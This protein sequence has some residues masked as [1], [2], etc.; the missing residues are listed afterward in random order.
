[1]VFDAATYG[2]EN[3]VALSNAVAGKWL[4]IEIYIGTGHIDGSNGTGYMFSLRPYLYGES[5]YLADLS[6]SKYPMDSIETNVSGTVLRSYQDRAGISVFK[7]SDGYRVDDRN[8]SGQNRTS[9]FLHVVSSDYAALKNTYKTMS[10]KIKMPTI[11]QNLVFYSGANSATFA[12][13]FSQ[14]NNVNSASNYF[15][16]L[17]ENGD[18][19]GYNSD[20]KLQ[21]NVWYTVVVHLEPC[22]T[23]KFVFCL[24]SSESAGVD[25]VY[26]IDDVTFS[27]EE[28]SV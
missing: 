12:A 24:G 26:Y 16:V 17:D 19:V 15:K 20:T 3:Q 4:V 7:Y 18:R 28:Y 2:T 1:K 14:T 10:F 13:S 6:V 5:I 25:V 27:T 11:S 9:L 22:S 21:S 23:D 8:G